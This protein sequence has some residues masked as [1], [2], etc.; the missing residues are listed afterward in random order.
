MVDKTYDSDPRREATCLSFVT[1]APKREVLREGAKRAD[2]SGEANRI[3]FR[4]DV[5]NHEVKRLCH[6]QSRAIGIATAL[7]EALLHIF[8]Q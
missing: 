2:D 1:T 6:V 5:Y 8:I 3:T 7:V 4:Q